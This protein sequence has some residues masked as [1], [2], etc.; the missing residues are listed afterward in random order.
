MHRRRGG[1]M[2]RRRRM[3]Q[4]AG[5]SC[6][7]FLY[8]FS[9]FLQNPLIVES[10]QI[11]EIV[12][13]SFKCERELM[14]TPSYSWSLVFCFSVGVVKRSSSSLPPVG[15]AQQSQVAVGGT[16]ALL[17]RR[18]RLGSSQHLCVL[19]QVGKSRVGSNRSVFYCTSDSRSF[20][21]P[22]VSTVQ[23]H[24]HFMHYSI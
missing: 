1:E 10:I 12:I 5:H 19:K 24:G 7:F 17:R 6:D 18:K 14:H 21:T 4:C 16:E 22:R 3:Q 9:H 20:F 2:G 15:G 11:L 8:P 23:I 13:L